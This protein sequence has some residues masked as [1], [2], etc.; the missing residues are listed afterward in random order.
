MNRII[1]VRHGETATNVKNVLHKYGDPNNLT[2]KGK[3]QIQ[4]TGNKLKEL[5]CSVLY[6]SNEIRALQSA[7]IISKI[8]NTLVIPLTG[9][10]ERNWG[11]YSGKP[12]SEIK[13]ILDPLSLDQRYE[14]VP[15]Q[16][17][18][19][20]DFEHRLISNIK[21]VNTDNSNVVIGIVTHGGSIRTLMPYLL[22]APKEESFK[23][24]PK[25]ASISIFDFNDNTIIPI[26]IDDTSHLSDT[27]A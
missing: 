23:Y 24:D 5:S 19:W 1:L 25:N 6:A 7:E 3:R 20:K 21:Q 11:D 12:W 2:E 14:F 26:L 22:S 15:P 4:E 9:M 27:S 16:G 17:E 13:T 8:C 10:G 18:S